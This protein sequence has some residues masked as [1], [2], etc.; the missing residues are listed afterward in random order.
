[1]AAKANGR[2]EAPIKAPDEAKTVRLSEDGNDEWRSRGPA[3]SGLLRKWPVANLTTLVVP[4]LAAMLVVTTLAG[5]RVADA[6]DLDARA[7]AATCRSCHQPGESVIPS[8]DG[9]S[10]AT[11]VAMLRGYRDGSRAG[12]VMP[13][14]VKGY[15][16]AELDAIAR[17]LAAKRQ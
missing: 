2:H 11:L 1:M 8:L 16:D 10:Y 7:L 12:T 17:Q 14:L 13:E 5:P 15:S 4:M 9:Q 6:A 3:P